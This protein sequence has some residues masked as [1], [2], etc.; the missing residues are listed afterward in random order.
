MLK[1]KLLLCAKGVVIDVK[2]NNVSVFNIMED[3]APA[4]F[5]IILV[6]LTVLNVLE[7]DS[8][9]PETVKCALRISMGSEILFE[10]AL[11]VDFQGK[12]RHRSVIALAGLPIRH[13]GTLVTTFEGAGKTM[14]RYEVTV[15]SPQVT[16]AVVSAS[17]T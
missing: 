3:I 12:P 8:G 11:D 15:Q 10:Q 7:R 16:A 1:S 9:D 2:T 14:A 4:S 6:E 13:P 5:P 17:S